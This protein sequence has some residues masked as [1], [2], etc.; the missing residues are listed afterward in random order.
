MPLNST[1][2]LKNIRLFGVRSETGLWFMSVMP[3]SSFVLPG[4]PSVVHNPNWPL[5]L[6]PSN[7]VWSLLRTVR[8]LGERP[9]ASAPV[10]GTNSK[11]PIAVPFVSHRP[12]WSRAL[13][14]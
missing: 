10:I 13:V 4:V 12:V 7:R 11:V 14:P 5:E 9:E 3:V 6:T 8:L 2:P 1:W